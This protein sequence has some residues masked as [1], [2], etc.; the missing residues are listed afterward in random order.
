MQQ[1]GWIHFAPSFK[2]KVNSILD[3]LDQEPGMVDEL[4]LGPIR[5]AYAELFFPGTSTVQTKARYFFI[6]S[7]LI[8]DFFLQKGG[9]S[10]DL[11]QYLQDEEYAIMWELAEKYHHDRNAGSGVI[12]ITKR[13]NET[14]ARRPS[15]IY[16]N[17]LRAY[18]FIDTKLSLSEYCLNADRLLEEILS[19]DRRSLEDRADDADVEFTNNHRIKVSTYVPGWRNQLDMP[20]NYEEADFFLKRIR[21]LFPDRLIGKLATMASLR[22]VFLSTNN[23][24]SFANQA[25]SEDIGDRLKR[26]IAQAHDLN[27]ITKG[28]HLA[29]SHLINHRYYENSFFLDRYNSWKETLYARFIALDSLTVESISETTQIDGNSLVNFINPILMLTKRRELHIELLE[30]LIAEQEGRM[31]GKKARLKYGS[32]PDFK[33]GEVKS[34]SHLNYRD[35]NT[36]TIIRDIFTALK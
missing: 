2:E 8:K 29:Y 18:R 9:K 32:Q 11:S 6:V 19:A 3:T 34:L 23:F 12:G 30:G 1:L 27:E 10:G 28:L 21:E 16:W 36:R 22:D 20:L 4:G 35:G 5:D 31:K 25:I 24:E 14:L 13:K 15:S 17:G 26:Q 7:Y 33:S